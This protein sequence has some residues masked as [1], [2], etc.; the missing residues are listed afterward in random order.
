MKPI[1]KYNNGNGAM[2]CNGCRTIISTGPKTEEVLCEE[3]IKRIMTVEERLEKY[4]Q[5]AVD[6]LFEPQPKI[7]KF[8][9]FISIFENKREKMKKEEYIQLIRAQEQIIKE[10]KRSTSLY[11][12]AGM[13]I[14][15]LV[16]NLIYIL[17][18]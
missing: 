8:E 12:I 1:H 14:G 4:N 16:T 11:L 15:V 9:G 7:E 13:T 6:A 2:L 18:K 5:E 10:L 3:C 17:L